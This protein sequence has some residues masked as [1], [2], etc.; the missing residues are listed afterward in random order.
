MKINFD[1]NEQN[2]L[3]ID[4]LKLLS[5][6]QKYSIDFIMINKRF[7]NSLKILID[8]WNDNK[9]DV[10]LNKYIISL[11]GFQT[12]M[13]LSKEQLDYSIKSNFI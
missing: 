7:S 9:N 1:K 13:E 2:N 5:I 4:N 3:S 8:V 10:E 11:P 12:N 6:I